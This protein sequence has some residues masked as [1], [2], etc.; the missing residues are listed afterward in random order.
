MIWTWC[1]H[2]NPIHPCTLL[3]HSL[4]CYR[5]YTLKHYNDGTRML[6]ENSIHPTHVCVMNVYGGVQFSQVD[7]I[8]FLAFVTHMTKYVHWATLHTHTHTHSASFAWFASLRDHIFMFIHVLCSR[9]DDAWNGTIKSLGEW[10]NEL[11]WN[12]CCYTWV[13]RFNAVFYTDND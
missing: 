1:M 5:I 12:V 8:M 13:Y 11:V 3:A 7:C 6:S 9:S 4:L 10:M 2:G